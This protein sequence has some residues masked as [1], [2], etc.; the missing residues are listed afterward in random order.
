MEEKRIAVIAKERNYLQPLRRLKRKQD[1]RES[2]RQWF[3]VGFDSEY[4][5]ASS[6]HISFQLYAENG[7]FTLLPGP[8]RR[9]IGSVVE[10]AYGL[11]RETTS[12]PT[13]PK[14]ILLIS[15]F[16]VA[17]LSQFAIPFWE[18][19]TASFYKVHP[20]GIFHVDGFDAING[21]QIQ[22]RIYDIWHFFASYKNSSLYKV[23]EDFGLQKLEYDVTN[24]TLENLKD[25]KFIAYAINDAKLCLEIFNVLDNQYIEQN[26][27]SI[28]D[29]PTAANAAQASFK[30]NYLKGEVSAPSR[31]IRQ[32]SLRCNWAGR[33]EC[34]RVG[35][36][37]KIH[38]LDADSLYPRST[39]LLPGLP[40]PDDWRYTIIKDVD[41]KEGF[42]DVEFAFPQDEEWP[43]LPVL[44]SDRKLYFPL[45]GRSY[46]TIGELRTAVERGVEIRRINASCYYS[47]GNHREFH[48]FLTDNL[49]L[50]DNPNKAVKAVAK[51]NMNSAIGKFIENKG[52]FDYEG[53]HKWIEDHP[54]IPE[55]MWPLLYT[56][57]FTV[58]GEQWQKS[59]RLGSSFYPEWHTLILGKAREVLARA[60]YNTESYPYIHM[61]STDSIIS[62]SNHIDRTMVPFKH[63]YGPCS[64]FAIRG[65]LY[66]AF[67]DRDHIIKVAHHAIPTNAKEA[68]E[69]IFQAEKIKEAKVKR[70]GMMTLR[71]SI[72]NQQMYGAEKFRE[73]NINF[74]Q[75]LK[76]RIDDQGWTH[77]LQIAA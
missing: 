29:R 30:L 23:A 40:S 20:A 63:E 61:V 6:T 50:K 60:I 58:K 46:C 77:P 33:V 35:E 48:D 73:Q 39:L 14:R 19:K 56:G 25:P 34:G 52:S 64:L 65:R 10:E 41:D 59:V 11:Y 68:A 28:I 38:E 44:G 2:S 49:R 37:E 53:V 3:K 43:C 36:S 54:E 69:L 21:H 51:L 45:E 42:V 5:S 22:W 15:Y 75:E 17:E 47:T 9:S 62:N 70:R 18:D 16:N 26:G 12:T 32:L 76:R 57:A 27:I 71:E 72:I 66:V 31:R 4:N 13:P 7:S 67:D 24:L 8:T 1:G 55:A 74:Q